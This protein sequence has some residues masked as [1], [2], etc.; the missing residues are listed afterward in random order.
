MS[1]LEM[2]I[3]VHRKTLLFF[4]FCKSKGVLCKV[5]SIITLELFCDAG[6]CA[7]VSV[8]YTEP[9]SSSKVM[10]LQQAYRSDSIET[11]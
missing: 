11:T 3:G 7:T 8:L 9:H 1:T 4:F 2:C 6:A 5:E 10:T